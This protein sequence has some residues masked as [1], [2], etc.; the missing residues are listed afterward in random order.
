LWKD[1]LNTLAGSKIYLDTSY[2]YSHLPPKW[3]KEIIKKHGADKILFGS[4]MPWSNTCDEI[5]FIESIGLSE[6]EMQQIFYKNATD[7][8]KI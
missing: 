4:D 8:L 5:R 1:V 6:V 3:A 7:I 2:S